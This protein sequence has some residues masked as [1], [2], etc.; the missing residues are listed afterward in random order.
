MNVTIELNNKRFSVDE[1]VAQHIFCLRQRIT[2]LTRAVEIAST[3]TDKDVEAARVNLKL[4][5]EGKPPLPTR[6]SD[7]RPFKARK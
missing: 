6:F 3:L 4:M 7:V 5:S 2:T 1:E